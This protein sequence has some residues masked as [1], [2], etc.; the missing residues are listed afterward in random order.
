MCRGLLWLFSQKCVHYRPLR[1]SCPGAADRIPYLLNFP[2]KFIWRGLS[3]ATGGLV[4]FLERS[5]QLLVEWYVTF[6]SVLGPSGKKL[7]HLERKIHSVVLW[8]EVIYILGGWEPEWLLFWWVFVSL[9]TAGTGSWMCFSHTHT[10]TFTRSS[11]YFCTEATPLSSY[12]LGRY[13]QRFHWR[14]E[15]KSNGV[16]MKRNFAKRLTWGLRKNKET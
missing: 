8:R 3:T 1:Y 2:R 15:E 7:R 6:R 5:S 12:A 10:H 9:E 14:R 4:T 11:F 16:R 13:Q